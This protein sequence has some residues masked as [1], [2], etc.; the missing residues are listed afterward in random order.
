MTWQ[1]TT[2]F[3][4]SGSVVISFLVSPH[5]LHLFRLEVILVHSQEI[6]AYQE[7]MTSSKLDNFPPVDIDE[8]GTFKYVLIEVYETSPDGTEKAK[9]LVRGRNSAEYHADIYEPEEERIMKVG[10]DC[11]CL[12]G[13]RIQHDAGYLKVYGYS[14]GYGKADHT[15][16]VALLEKRYPEYKI[17]WSDSGY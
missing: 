12:G 1:T 2:R 6:C 9:L 7:S 14:M 5:L 4:I 16:A 11:Q 10:L 17:E 15:K 3:A 8:K 13:G